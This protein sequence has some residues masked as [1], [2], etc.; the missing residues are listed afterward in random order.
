VKES[1][2]KTLSEVVVMGFVEWLW[3]PDSGLAGSVELRG[4]SG[5]GSAQSVT[6]RKKKVSTF[7]KITTTKF[8]NPT[9]SF[10][11]NH[12]PHKGVTMDFNGSI[13]SSTC[14]LYRFKPPKGTALCSLCR[15]YI[16]NE[17]RVR[18]SKL[19]LGL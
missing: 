14:L 9:K 11:T 15:V 10:N 5:K 2:D 12:H 16:L 4:D 8:K 3:P 17:T 7:E 13:G 18:R 19:G 1:N 6:V